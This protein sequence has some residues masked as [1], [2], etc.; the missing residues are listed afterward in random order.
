[1]KYLNKPDQILLEKIIEIKNKTTED[2]IIISDEGI[3]GRQSIG[4][5]D[6][7]YRLELLE[8]LFNKPKYVIFFRE[9]SSMIYSIYKQALK[10]RMNLKFEKYINTKIEYSTSIENRRLSDGIDYKLFDYNVIFKDYLSLEDRVLF[11]EF[12]KFFNKDENE[13]KKFNNFLGIKF[14]FDF[15]EVFK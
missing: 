13:V 5:Y 8:S 3:F 14:N 6:A 11:V 10:T 7:S 12:S 15:S 4:Y 2:N 1:M 9:P